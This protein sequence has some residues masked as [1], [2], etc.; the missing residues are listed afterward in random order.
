[1][2]QELIASIQT[3][4]DGVT[5]ETM[6]MQRAM[7]VRR[8]K[9]DEHLA[10]VPSS[11]MQGVR[12]A[13]RTRQWHRSH[14]EAVQIA[15]QPSLDARRAICKIWS[16]SQRLNTTPLEAYWQKEDS[17][18][19]MLSNKPEVFPK[20]SPTQ[21]VEMQT[22]NYDD[23][24]KPMWLDNNNCLPIWRVV[25]REPIERLWMRINSQWVRD[26]KRSSFQS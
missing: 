11:L 8:E 20:P 16:V 7:V 13:Q 14:E 26:I 24:D 17:S 1:M 21:R 18:M 15:S 19:F 22:R 2:T 23:T 12:Q 9:L 3:S 10:S 25:W 6:T 4:A 5:T